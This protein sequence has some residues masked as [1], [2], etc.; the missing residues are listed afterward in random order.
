MLCRNTP[1]KQNAEM[2]YI[3]TDLKQSVDN[4]GVAFFK[5]AKERNELYKKKN[6]Q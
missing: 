6:K 5:G 3:F 1:V 4:A 2:R